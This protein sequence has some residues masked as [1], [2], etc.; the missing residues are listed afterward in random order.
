MV[1]RPRFYCKILRPHLDIH[2]NCFVKI[3][4]DRQQLPAI[5]KTDPDDCEPNKEPQN[6]K[7][8]VQICFL[9][10][11][12]FQRSAVTKPVVTYAPTRV[13]ELSGLKYSQ[14]LIDTLE[15]SI[16]PQGL[17]Q[18]KRKNTHSNSRESRDDRRQ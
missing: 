4:P 14:Q 17:I 7:A 10:F 2:S 12:P 11:D 8:G 6:E 3:H 9:M 16:H 13:S 5:P 1:L 15:M 18:T